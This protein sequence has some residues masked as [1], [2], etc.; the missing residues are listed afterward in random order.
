MRGINEKIPQT[1]RRMP[2]QITRQSPSNSFANLH[3]KTNLEHDGHCF[4]PPPGVPHS[5]TTHLKIMIEECQ[6]DG[7]EREDEE[8]SKC[9]EGEADLEEIH[10]R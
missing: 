8:N 1:L 6:D 4:L 2:S 5:V 7:G 10:E 9:R 3:N